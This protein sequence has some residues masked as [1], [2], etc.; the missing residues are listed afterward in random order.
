MFM[1]VSFTWFGPDH[2]GVVGVPDG[3]IQVPDIPRKENSLFQ[4]PEIRVVRDQVLV[5]GRHELAAVVGVGQN[6][7]L[8]FREPARPWKLLEIGV[9][10]GLDVDDVLEALGREL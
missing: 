3:V 2:R 5:G 10:V 1:N 6:Q 7:F 9:I 4:V 8:D